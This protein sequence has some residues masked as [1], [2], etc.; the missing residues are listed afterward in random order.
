M[1]VNKGVVFVKSYI[2]LVLQNLYKSTVLGSDCKQVTIVFNTKVLRF[3]KM[4]LSH[5]I[6]LGQSSTNHFR[7][8]AC[9]PSAIP[10]HK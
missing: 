3:S 6:C 8:L 7:K 4:K 2:G 9:V 1:F 10:V 5:I